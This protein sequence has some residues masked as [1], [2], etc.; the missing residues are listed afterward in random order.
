VRTRAHEGCGPSV[1]C[2]NHLYG[3]LAVDVV[4]RKEATTIEAVTKEAITSEVR[5]KDAIL[6]RK[7]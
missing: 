7:S 4:C 2:T 1:I 3:S 6:K 5:T